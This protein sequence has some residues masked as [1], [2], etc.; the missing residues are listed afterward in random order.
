MEEA[1]ADVIDVGGES[2][3][4][5]SKPVSAAEEIARTLPVIEA[6]ALRTAAPLSIDTRKAEVAEAGAS[7][8]RLRRQ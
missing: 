8:R 7:R 1:G 4:P 3:R 2:T 5:G 6:L